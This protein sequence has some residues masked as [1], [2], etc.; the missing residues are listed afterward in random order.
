MSL[1]KTQFIEALA[2]KAGCDHSE[3]TRI[4]AA[5]AQIA[6]EILGRDGAVRI[7]DLVDLT[8]RQQKARRVRHLHTGEMIDVSARRVVK[9]KPAPAMREAV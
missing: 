8:V 9:A 6:H 1:R 4:C 3:A 7:P 5:V 2:T